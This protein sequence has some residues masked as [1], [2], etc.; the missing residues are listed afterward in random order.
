LIALK[1]ELSMAFLC[2]PDDDNKKSLRE[3]HKSPPAKFLESDIGSFSAFAKAVKKLSDV[4]D[5]ARD[6]RVRAAARAA[7]ADEQPLAPGPAPLAPADPAPPRAAQVHSAAELSAALA[8]GGGVARRGGKYSLD[9]EMNDELQRRLTLATARV[10]ALTLQLI[11]FEACH[12]VV[13][14]FF[15]GRIVKAD[16]VYRLRRIGGREWLRS[17]KKRVPI[18]KNFDTTR[19]LEAQRAAKVQ[20]EIA[21]DFF[22][23]TLYAHALAQIS[24]A[25]GAGLVVAGWTKHPRGGVA[26]RVAADG[27]DSEWRDDVLELRADGAYWVKPLNQPLEFVPAARVLNFDEKPLYLDSVMLQTLCVEASAKGSTERCTITPLFSAAGVLLATQILL[28]DAISDEQ[29]QT[30]GVARILK[31]FDERHPR[32]ADEVKVG[33][34]GAAAGTQTDATML[35]TVTELFLPAMKRTWAS[36]TLSRA[37]FSSTVTPRIC[38]TPRSRCCART[39]SSWS[40]IRRTR[41]RGCK[42]LISV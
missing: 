3:F 20:P 19:P 40:R 14:R 32:D 25:V 8:R 7:A 16:A 37:C 38:T 23:Y 18:V 4:A 9:D 34:D 6:A 30:I 13:E 36:L 29:G 27:G 10:G 31:D 26:C 5:A 39:T 41:R 15:D 42:R 12:I 2:Q 35:R 11:S 1:N 17:T 28:R 22:R 24:A 21:V 33:I